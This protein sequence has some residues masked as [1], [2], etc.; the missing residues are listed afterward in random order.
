[1][2]KFSG[3]KKFIFLNNIDDETLKKASYHFELK[4]VQKDDYLFHEAEPSKF[5]A[6]LIKGKISFQKSKIFSKDTGEMI[7]RSL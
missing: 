5:F 2:L 6:G 3:F 1:M 4:F 7:F